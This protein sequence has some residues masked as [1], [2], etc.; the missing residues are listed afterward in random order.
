MS[1]KALVSRWISDS[2]FLISIWESDHGGY[3][4][5]LAASPSYKYLASDTF[6]T[7]AFEAMVRANYLIN[8]VDSGWKLVPS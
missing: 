8:E 1:K 4:V 6:H 2:R 5:V 7:Q 3:H